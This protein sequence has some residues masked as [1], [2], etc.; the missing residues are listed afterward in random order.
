MLADGSCLTCRKLLLATGMLDDLP[1]VPGL[2]ELYGVS[3]HHC[4]YCDGWEHR[5]QA[6]AVY[7]RGHEGAG[8][9]LELLP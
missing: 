8:L 7:G 6:P 3:M 1:P 9:A 4:S 2:R 5:D